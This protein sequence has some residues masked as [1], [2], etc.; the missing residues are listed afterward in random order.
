MKGGGTGFSGC[1][2]SAVVC[3]CLAKSKQV[4]GSFACS[5]VRR[6][7]PYVLEERDGWGGGRVGR[8]R[9]R[10]KVTLI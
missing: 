1:V 8:V 4:T 3:W 9:C 2:P 10:I 6:L 7:D 5:A